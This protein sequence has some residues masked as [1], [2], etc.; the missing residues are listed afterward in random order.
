MGFPRSLLEEPSQGA[1]SRSLPKEPFR[2]TFPRSLLEEPSQGAHQRPDQKKN[3]A[4][5]LESRPCW[6]PNLS[7]PWLFGRFRPTIRST[8]IASRASQGHRDPPRSPQ[9][10]RPKKRNQKKLGP[11]F[12]K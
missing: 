5:F 9:E 8:K 2:R 12:G 6:E 1:F 7:I 4:Q 10:D 11:V 3:W